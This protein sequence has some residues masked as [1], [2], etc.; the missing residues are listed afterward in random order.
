MKKRIRKGFSCMMAASIATMTMIGCSQGKDDQYLNA[1]ELKI[2]IC[3]GGLGYHWAELVAEKF[4]ETYKNVSFEDGKVGV[5]VNINPQKDEFSIASIGAAISN[6]V[7]AEDMYFTFHDLELKFAKLGYAKNLNDAVYEKCFTDDGQIA[8]YDPETKTYKNGTMSI[9]DKLFDVHKES[10]YLDKELSAFPELEKG[11]YSLPYEDCLSGFIYDYDL[12]K[13][14][15]WLDYDGIDGL[16]D[17]ED[18]FFDLLDRIVEAGIIPFT[19]ANDVTWYM[20]EGFQDA[21]FA[22]YEG[23]DNA[24]LCYTYD[25]EY[26][27]L[28]DDLPLD[29]VNQIKDEAY[30]EETENGY[31]V[32]ID[33]KNAWLLAYQPSKNAY[34]RFLRKLISGN[35]F[36]S[37]NFYKQTYSFTDAQ[38]TFIMSKLGKANQ[39]RIAMIQEGEWWENEARAYFNYTGGY[40][41]REFRFFPLPYI[42]GQKDKTVRSLGNYSR[43][44]D[45]FINNKTKKYDLCKLFLQFSRSE[46]SLETFTMETGITQFYK[47]DLDDA[48]LQK[49]TPF[50]R[51]VYKIKMTDE[52]GITVVTA[53]DKKEAS[54]FFNS[55]GDTVMGGMGSWIRNY[56]GKN[57]AIIYEDTFTAFM[58]R[59]G[60]AGS[61]T[62]LLS[63]EDYIKGVRQ[64]YTKEKWEAAYSSYKN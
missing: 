31:T 9:Y 38:Q 30:F 63:A 32:S 37:S 39:K 40:G 42:A 11:F 45:I 52:S 57:G 47:Y 58:K 19:S 23:Y 15:G 34:A 8:E 1:T 36:D 33:E 10:K 50:G 29:I 49:L 17:T 18:D 16:P 12:F 20:Q 60:V 64:F 35:Y 22:Q 56:A 4:E 54:N 27:F 2:G 59:S 53:K 44:S 46:E 62:T 3:N 61:G 25:G 24:A 5:K 51:N 6:N 26:T 48:Q 7:N 28:K 21:F 43:G 13:E 55:A 41:T 14:R